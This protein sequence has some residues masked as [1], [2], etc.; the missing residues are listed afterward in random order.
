MSDSHDTRPLVA[1]VVVGHNEKPL[2][3]DC[4]RSLRT[5][6][7]A[8]LLVVYADNESS[9]GSLEH[10][11]TEFPEVIGI[12][13]GG[14]LGYCGGNN[15][16]ITRALE[17]GA[18]FVL[19]L[20]PDTIVCNPGFITTL[21]DYMLVHPEV[22]KVGPK[23][24]LYDRGNVQNTILEWPSIV[25]SFRS[26][27]ETLLRRKRT[28]KSALVTVP[29]D[30]ES[31]NGCC[32]LVR[33]EALRDV[34]LYDPGFWCYVDEVDWDWQAA[35]A[36]WQ[37]HYVPVESIVHLPRPANYD[38][39]SRANYYMKRN[40]ALWYAKNGKWISALAWM[41]ITLIVALGR[42]ILAPFLGRSPIK[43]CRFLGKL[44]AAYAGVVADLVRGKV[45]LNARVELPRAAAR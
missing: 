7:Y 29:I 27:L 31:L 24:Y 17:A 34:G 30:V 25:V 38:F 16:G 3:S 43:Y 13:S 42:C 1:I 12:P 39:A 37:R 2:V 44:A 26:V 6:D 40:T 4:F 19:I 22:G 33:A 41:S 23:V 5:I 21:V 9:D 14:N 11:K 45:S 15:V 18:R 8:P 10:V 32:A 28:A 20:N 35:R 36:G